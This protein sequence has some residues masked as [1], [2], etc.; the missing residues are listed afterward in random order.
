MLPFLCKCLDTLAKSGVHGEPERAFAVGCALLAPAAWLWRLPQRLLVEAVSFCDGRS[1]AALDATCSA[2]GR[3]REMR[4]VGPSLL[5]QAVCASVRGTAPRVPLPGRLHWAWHRHE[6]DGARAC[7]RLCGDT[8]DLHDIDLVQRSVWVRSRRDRAAALV[9]AHAL[10]TGPADK[11]ASFIGALASLDKDVAR[12]AGAVSA[13]VT[14]SADGCMEAQ[15]RA[16]WALCLVA[17]RNTANQ[18]AIRKAGGISIL[19]WL[20]Q[21]GSLEAKSNAT[22]ALARLSDGNVTNQNAIIHQEGLPLLVNLLESSS[23]LEGRRRAALTVINLCGNPV[24]NRLIGESRAIPALVRL[25]RE[26]NRPTKQVTARAIYHLSRDSANAGVI[27]QEGGLL[28]LVELVRDGGLCEQTWSTRALAN[29]DA[30]D[31]AEAA[32]RTVDGALPALVGLL[33]QRDASGRRGSCA[34]AATVI[35]QLAHNSGIRDALLECNVVDRLLQ[36]AAD[37]K[38]HPPSQ[39]N[40]RDRCAGALR[41][42]LDPT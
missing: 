39:A 40:I 1:L 6:L 41:L 14:L 24:N 36:L 42:L 8:D 28:S 4:A 3:R 35:W 32:F 16:S 31:G 11:R 13:M 21:N 20:L 33:T 9:L 30:R 29:L 19:L 17:T 38:P 26:G 22:M 5:E 12:E 34:G 7:A 27:R 18:D 37:L 2:V 23:I 15:E 10:S 25:L